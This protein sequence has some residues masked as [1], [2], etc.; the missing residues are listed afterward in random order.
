MKKPALWMA[1]LL[2][3]LTQVQAQAQGLKL[4]V[5]SPDWRD[6]IIYFVLTDRFADGD[7]KNNNQGHGE[8]DPAKPD[9][10]NGGDLKGLT[11]RLDYIRGLNATAVW[12][13]PPVLNQWH[14]P[15]L[16]YWGYHGYW[17][18]HFK[19]M[20]PHVG[21]LAEY[22][23]L[24]DAL[25]RR[26]MVLVQDIVVNHTGNYFEYGP[27][28]KADE[29]AHDYIPNPR[30][31][32][33]TAP[34]QPPFHLND[35]RQAQHRAAAIYHWTPAMRDVTVREQEL[36][37]QT[38]SLDDLNTG[39]PVVRRALRDSFGYW[40]R[41]VGVDGFRVDT[42]YHVEPEFF[43]DFMFSR[44]RKA[45]GVAEVAR[46]TGRND[47]LVFGEGFGIDKPSEQR[48]AKKLE[49]YVRGED[50]GRRMSGMLNFPL[51][52]GLVDVFARGR[53][54]SELA[55]RVEAMVEAGQRG[56]SPHLLPSFIDNHDVDR[57]LAGGSVAAMKQALLAVMT[58]PGIPVL[59]YGTEQGFSLQRPAMFAAGWG[60]GGRDHYDTGSALYRYTAAVSALRREHRLF[61]RGTPRIVHSSGAAPGALA[62]R[63]EH[64]GRAAIV[65]FNS[66]DEERLLDNLDTGVANARLVPL[67]D[68]DGTPGQALLADASG[69]VQLRLPA[70]AG[71]VWWVQAP[72]NSAPLQ[73][74]SGPALD[75]LPKAPFQGDFDVTG[76]AAAGQNVQ[77]VI[78]GDLARA[79]PARS[80]AQGRFSA[81]VDTRR[82]TDAGLPHRIVVLD[83]SLSQASPAQTFNTDLPWHLLADVEDPAGDDRGPDGRYRYPSHE[84]YSPGQMDLRRIKALQAGGA[85]RIELEMG[86]LSRV[87]GPSNGFDHVAFTIFVELPDR[88]GGTPVMPQQNAML[89]QGMRWHLRLRAHGWSNALF[90]AAGASA[91]NEG[92][93]V[94]PVASIQTDA[95][96]RTVT[97][98]IPSA[99]LG[100]PATLSGAR[101]YVTTWDYDGGYRAL[102]PEA[103]TFVFGGGDP[104]RDA[105]VMDASAVIR[106]P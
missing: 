5:P 4:H 6:Q 57:F 72:S 55:A 47:F 53:P 37:F 33:S 3:L 59:Y 58:L 49:A 95:Q 65:A 69:R 18:Q 86:A 81:R 27:G 31:V 38:S 96:R 92:T 26:G 99:A 73:S 98:T 91:T 75:E 60:S 101:L 45:P 15:L 48:F 16:G 44:D 68:I 7:P 79:L 106:L 56:V 104:A 39:N 63:T 32:P 62:W 70:R 43:N 1:A 36:T 13:T 12:I 97:F 93:P 88:E 67:F 90:S 19:R 23:Q 34:T 100:D 77:I 41:E 83:S 66:A 102:A 84:S 25:H 54:P 20:D 2:P 76:H 103:G 46:R 28:W 40:I 52:A 22:R 51:Y 24:S 9:R 35:P 17:A 11:Q 21:T 82:M 14:E 78:D 30:S 50:G 87:W 85:L 89:P 8:Y 71:R 80:D 61:S 64:E 105:K 94:T 10:Y 42:A 29:P 74:V